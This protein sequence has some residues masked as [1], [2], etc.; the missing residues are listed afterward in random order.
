VTITGVGP[1]AT[2]GSADVNPT[3]DTTYTLTASNSKFTVTKTVTVKVTPLPPPVD[4]NKPPVIVLNIPDSTEVFYREIMLDASASTDPQGK[5]LKFEWRV[6]SPVTGAD[7]TAASVWSPYEAKT[8]VQIRTLGE[9]VLQVK[10]TNQA[11]LSTTKT[12][13][14]RLYYPVR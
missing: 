3:V 11:G 1:V 6:I 13:T 10:A 7:N 12:I 4:N 14:L 8:L 2:S 9:I 5:P